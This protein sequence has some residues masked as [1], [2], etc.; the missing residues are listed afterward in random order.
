MRNFGPDQERAE[1]ERL[2][3]LICTAINGRNI[4][5][6]ELVSPNTGP[7][8]FLDGYIVEL[9]FVQ[10]AWCRY[11]GAAKAVFDDTRRQEEAAGLTDPD[12]I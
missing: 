2:A 9:A 11:L 4:D 1:L 7:R 12:A 10:P 5:C 8:R 3:R 6:D